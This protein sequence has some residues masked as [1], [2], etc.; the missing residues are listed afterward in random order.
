[1]KFD[2]VWALF[3][4]SWRAQAKAHYINID[5]LPMTEMYVNYSDWKYQI[6][7]YF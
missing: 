1:M 7:I 6:L 3:S 4:S 2:E 5:S